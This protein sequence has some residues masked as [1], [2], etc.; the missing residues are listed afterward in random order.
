MGYMG[1]KTEI[2]QRAASV[3]CGRSSIGDL[4]LDV[5]LLVLVVLLIST[6]NRYTIHKAYL[7]HLQQHL[8]GQFQPLERLLLLD[9]NLGNILNMLVIIGT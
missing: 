8:F 6:T 2:D 7:E 5:V 3:D 4:V 9:S 1:T